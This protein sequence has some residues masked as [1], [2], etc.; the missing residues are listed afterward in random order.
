MD[1]DDRLNMLLM[2]GKMGFVACPPR[3]VHL[4]QG[5]R[6]N[7][8]ISNRGDTSDNRV[9]RSGKRS[10]IKCIDVS[11]S[12]SGEKKKG[13]R[14]ISTEEVF[15]IDAGRDLFFRGM[16]EAMAIE[17]LEKD[18]GEIEDS[19]DRFI[20]AERLKFFPS[21]K[22]ARAL[23]DFVDRFERSKV[24]EYKMEERIA[25]RKA[26]ETLG[27]HKGAY[28]AD[29]VKEFLA[30]YFQDADAHVVENA[31]W[32]IGEI[33]GDLNESLLENV[34][35]VLDQEKLDKRVVI[36]TLLRAGYKPAV[37]KL[38]TLAKSN[39]LG[40]ST[41]AMSAVAVLSGDISVMEPVI[42]VLKSEDLNARRYAIEDIKLGGYTEAMSKV[43][44]C[45]N[46]LVLRARTVRSLLDKRKEIES[47]LEARLDDDTARMIDRLIW[48]H[49]GDLD[50]LGMK[51]ETRR[52]RDLTRN[53]KQL[54]K[55]D[56]LYNYVACR[57]IAEDY[58]GENNEEAGIAVTKSYNELGYFD[59]F[60]A[61]HVYKTLGW[62]GYKAG[63]DLLIENALELPPRFF[64]HKAGAITALAELGRTD[65]LETI[66]SI[67]LESKIW[68]VK[69]ACLIASERLGDGGCLRERLRQDSDWVVRAR[70]A[71]DIEFDHLRNTFPK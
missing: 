10:V 19:E 71:N 4:V 29:E 65:A 59:Y 6:L 55:N 37:E 63:Y 41:A 54:Y 62:I 38:R 25:R 46:S 53:V 66:A 28:I 1:F 14:E 27:R 12:T 23:M 18:F 20:A 42:K 8:D 7:K 40:V 69:Y 21:E 35:S 43:V 60:G 36:Q 52:A 31:I 51:K 11:Q 45:P 67:A 61:Y 3:F 70:C 39:D 15:A 9:I 49:P 24:D 2:K 32:A 5:G 57:T 64:N 22:S 16:D 44:I 47:G 13:G 48:D 17:I 68:E 58:R 26:V 34:V 30:Q 56:A 33:G 50:L